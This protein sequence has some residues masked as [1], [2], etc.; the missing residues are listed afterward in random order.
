MFYVYILFSES[1]DKYYVGHSNDYL[2]RLN[3]HNSNI[4]MTFTHKYKPWK[5]KAF[6]KVNEN[7]GDAMKI[8]KY[9]KRQKSRKVII[10]LINDPEYFNEIAQLVGVP[11]CRD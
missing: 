1:F 8:E 4:R 7:R 2:R 3:E 9:I 5:L 10:R 11:I 6:F